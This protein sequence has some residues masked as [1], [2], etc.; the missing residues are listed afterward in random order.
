MVQPPRDWRRREAPVPNCSSLGRNR[1]RTLGKRLLGLP[2]SEI[3]AR[4][5]VPSPSA[6]TALTGV[7]TP[8]PGP[9]AGAQRA[10]RGRGGGG[11]LRTDAPPAPASR[12]P[13]TGPRGSQ[14]RGAPPPRA[15]PPS[16][17]P[18]LHGPRPDCGVAG[19]RL[20]A[21][22]EP[23][24]RSVDPAPRGGSPLRRPCRAEPADS[25]TLWEPGTERAAEA[26]PAAPPSG[27]PRIAQKRRSR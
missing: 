23:L 15:P 9:R 16:S 10:S 4:R 27:R 6:V 21:P 13:R 1:E 8:P 2:S 20:A 26:G 11:D 7:P 24:A 17:M 14:R 5:S 18:G 12:A 3:R 25:G 22:S 19:T